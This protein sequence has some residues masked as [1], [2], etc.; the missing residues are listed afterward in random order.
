MLGHCNDSEMYIFSDVDHH[1]IL[2]YQRYDFPE[3]VI[4]QSQQKSDEFESDDLS[5]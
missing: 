2:T 1:V 5:L 4:T 3:G